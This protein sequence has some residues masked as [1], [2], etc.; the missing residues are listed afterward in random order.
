ML[1]IQVV[2]EVLTRIQHTAIQE[3][4]LCSSDSGIR[5][6]LLPS[7]GLSSK[8]ATHLPS[9]PAVAHPTKESCLSERSASC[10]HGEME[11]LGDRQGFAGQGNMA[12]MQLTCGRPFGQPTAGQSEYVNPMGGS[13]INLILRSSMK[14]IATQTGNR[15]RHRF[16]QLEQ[17]WFAIASWPGCSSNPSRQNYAV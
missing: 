9:S 11:I 6:D 16:S 15:R 12:P 4:C 13:E 14:G 3:C 1:S 7:E 5:A 8:V 10:N 17:P 2:E